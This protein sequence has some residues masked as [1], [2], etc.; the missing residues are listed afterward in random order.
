MPTLF[1]EDLSEVNADSYD[2]EDPGYEKEPVASYDRKPSRLDTHADPFARR[3]GKTLLWKDVNMTLVRLPCPSQLLFY[4]V[5][6]A[7]CNSR[8]HYVFCHSSIVNSRARK[9]ASPTESFSTMSGVRFHKKKRRPL[10]AP[11]ELERLRFL[12]F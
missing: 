8:E 2:V 1:S 3:E 11:V 6:H 7:M 12:T 5:L 4:D 9:A 10:W